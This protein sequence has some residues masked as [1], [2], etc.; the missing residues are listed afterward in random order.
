M[1]ITYNFQYLRQVCRVGYVPYYFS[2]YSLIA[3]YELL[4]AQ[5]YSK[6]P[7]SY[8]GKK[9]QIL[10]KILPGGFLNPVTTLRVLKY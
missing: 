7:L 3:T 9:S 2:I 4:L 1:T 5:D 6:Q 8:L 10:L